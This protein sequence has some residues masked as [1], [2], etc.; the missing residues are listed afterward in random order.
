[1]MGGHL[2]SYTPILI[3]A[4]VPYILQRFTVRRASESSCAACRA[5]LVPFS[6]LSEGRGI[7]RVSCHP[8]VY[9]T[10]T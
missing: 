10:H 4:H 2:N 1:M 8:K 6:G 7:I 5:R 3:G 9:G